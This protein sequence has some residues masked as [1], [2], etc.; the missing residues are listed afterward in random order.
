[1]SQ[2]GSIRINSPEM[3]IDVCE[4]FGDELFVYRGHGA[5]N[6]KLES[7]IERLGLRYGVEQ[8]HLLDREGHLFEQF[9]ERAHHYVDHVPDDDNLLEWAALIQHYGGPTRLLDVTDSYWVAAF[10]AV[11]KPEKDTDSEIW[12]FRTNPFGELIRESMT[13]TFKADSKRPRVKLAK[14]KRLNERMVA[15]R[16]LFMVPSNLGDTFESQLQ[17]TTGSNLSNVTIFEKASDIP[18]FHSSEINIW[19]VQI[20]SGLQSVMARFLKRSNITAATLFPGVEG[21]GRSLNLTMRLFD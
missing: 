17:R 20:P 5:T 10:F 15:Q 18:L 6:W 9:K 8:H 12:A 19:R 1:M 16:G 2:V 14:P 7:T 4:R 21:I 3:F 11:E 13:D